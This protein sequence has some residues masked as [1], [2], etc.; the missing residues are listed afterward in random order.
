MVQ[1]SV[2]HNLSKTKALKTADKEILHCVQNDNFRITSSYATTVFFS[3]GQDS[4]FVSRNDSF[5]VGTS[6]PWGLEFSFFCFYKIDM[7]EIDMYTTGLSF[8]QYTGF[9]PTADLS[10]VCTYNGGT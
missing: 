10:Y 7:G 8:K 6:V 1:C 2:I 9:N 3:G 4:P 5:E